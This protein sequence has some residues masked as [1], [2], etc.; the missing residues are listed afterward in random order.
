[1]VLFKYINLLTQQEPAG[2]VT[3]ALVLNKSLNREYE[4]AEYLLNTKQGEILNRY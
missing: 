1:M 2:T 3:F 4:L